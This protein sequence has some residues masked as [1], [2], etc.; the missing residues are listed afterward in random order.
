MSRADLEKQPQDVASMFD[1]IAGRYDLM[2]D[3]AAL[4]QVGMWRDL[5]VDALDLA[6]GERVLDLAA[7]T[8]TSSAAIALRQIMLGDSDEVAMSVSERFAFTT[9]WMSNGLLNDPDAEKVGAA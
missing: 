8:G 9:N 6:Q 7:G 5:M 2:N 3:I 1:G 4:G